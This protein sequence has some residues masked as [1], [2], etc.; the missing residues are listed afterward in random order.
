MCFSAFNFITALPLILYPALMSTNHKCTQPC[1][2]PL[3]YNPIVQKLKK[4]LYSS[5]RS[6]RRAITPGQLTMELWCCS[7]TVSLRVFV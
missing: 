4:I 2:S 6:S 7:T 1:Y 3:L 5:M